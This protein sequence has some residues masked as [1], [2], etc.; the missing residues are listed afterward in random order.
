MNP[1]ITNSY[2]NL[3]IFQDIFIPLV[4]LI[5]SSAQGIE[6]DFLGIT[7]KI[8]YFSMIFFENFPKRIKAHGLLLGTQ[9]YASS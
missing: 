6:Y 3:S 8:A 5:S 9:K 4:F 1:K 7:S 2:P